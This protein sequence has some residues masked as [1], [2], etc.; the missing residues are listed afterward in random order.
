MMQ[1]MKQMQYLRVQVET[2]SPGEL[3]LLLYQELVK[4][5]LRA[6]QCYSQNEY[7]EMGK[8]LHKSRAIMSELTVT[9]NKEYEIANS[10]HQLYT[11][12]SNH[13]AQF[14]VSKDEQILDDVIEF[15]RDM[16]DTWKKALN[17]LKVSGSTANG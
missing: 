13:L 16:A 14:I 2:A 4:S 11:F 8:F 17:Q 6:K 15:A 12:Y 9:L 7:E 3:T 1:N 5:L 10:L